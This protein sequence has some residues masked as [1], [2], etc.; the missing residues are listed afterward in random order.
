MGEF[1]RAEVKTGVTLQTNYTCDSESYMYIEIEL[2]LYK[3]CHN[4]PMS[5][6]GFIVIHLIKA[7][8]RKKLAHIDLFAFVC[9]TRDSNAGV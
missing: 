4:E 5:F 9:A 3:C 6:E 7:R 8:N 2:K 1:V